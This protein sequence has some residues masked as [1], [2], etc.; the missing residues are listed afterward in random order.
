[1]YAKPLEATKRGETIEVGSWAEMNNYVKQ[2]EKEG[3]KVVDI[4]EMYTTDEGMI[5]FCFNEIEMY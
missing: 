2:M 1:M 4:K 5:V 3:I